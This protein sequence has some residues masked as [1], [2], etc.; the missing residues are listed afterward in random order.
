MANQYSNSQAVEAYVYPGE[1]ER[2]F[3]RFSYSPEGV[4][5]IKTV[6][7]RRWEQGAKC[8]SI[9]ESKESVQKLAQLFKVKKATLPL[10]HPDTNHS[11]S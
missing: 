11:Y 6:P 5:K 3:V 8:W 10:S 1:G 4:E 9:P 2:L 7:G